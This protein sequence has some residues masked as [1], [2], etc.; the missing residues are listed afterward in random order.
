MGDVSNKY[1][2]RD[3]E[4]TNLSNFKISREKTPV[5]IGAISDI[6]V[7]I[8]CC[9]LLKNLLHKPLV[10]AGFLEEKLDDS[11]EDL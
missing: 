11:C 6:W 10:V 7:I 8:V 1:V 5:N 9:G 2:L 3:V 4:Q